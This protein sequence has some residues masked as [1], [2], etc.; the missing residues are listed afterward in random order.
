MVSEAV[1]RISR[2]VRPACW[3]DASNSTPTSRP[4]LG[5][6]ANRSPLM[7][8][9][10][11][12]GAVGP[13][14][15]RIVVDLPAPFGPRKPVTRPGRAV[16]E[17]LSTAVKPAYLR[18]SDS[19]V[20][21]WQPS[22]RRGVRTSA[23]RPDPPPPLGGAGSR[24][25]GRSLRP[26]RS[27]GWAGDHRPALAVGRARRSRRSRTGVARL[28]AGRR[29]DGGGVARGSPPGRRRLAAGRDDRDGR[30]CAG[31]AMAAYPPVGLRHGGLRH[32]DGVGT[33]E[34]AERDPRRGPQH[35]DLHPGARLRAGP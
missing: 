7:V 21:M 34:L 15:T 13:T 8:A 2:P 19:T 1:V 4:G 26:L 12:V 29:G 33:G 5:R 27:L 14:M 28:G 9:E 18:V 20:I 6:S 30:T 25:F 35:D 22:P 17:T 3:A 31:A 23:S 16:K 11:D 32:R 24:S 10:P